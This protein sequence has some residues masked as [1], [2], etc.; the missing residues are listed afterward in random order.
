MKESPEL[1]ILTER[2]TLRRWAMADHPALLNMTSR[3]DV[4]RYVP[5]PPRTAESAATALEQRIGWG[6]PTFD[7]DGQVL[8][9]AVEHTA[10]GVLIGD[11]MLMFRTVEHRDAEIGFIFHPDHQ[12]QGYATEVGRAVLSLAFDHYGLHRVF[13]R[14]DARNQASARLLAR[15]GMRQEAHLV[16]NEWFKGEWTDELIFAILE[17]EQTGALRDD[18]RS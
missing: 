9:L 8:P 7:A 17:N 1:P 12:G 10:S 4:V 13:A 3:P 15:L 5:F 18:P 11:F 6:V 14:L 2:L 16:A